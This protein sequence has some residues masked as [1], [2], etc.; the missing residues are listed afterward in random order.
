MRFWKELEGYDIKYI[1]KRTRKKLE[2]KSC[3]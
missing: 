1:E 3:I 2:A